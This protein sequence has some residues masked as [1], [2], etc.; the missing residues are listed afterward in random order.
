MN[1]L[2]DSN[3]VEWF[4]KEL[5]KMS[6]NN[7][8]AQ[9]DQSSTPKNFPSGIDSWGGLQT[10]REGDSFGTE[11]LRPND[12]KDTGVNATDNRAVY[13]NE[14]AMMAPP[15]GLETL[16]LPDQAI[17]HNTTDGSILESVRQE[18]KR[19]DHEM[20]QVNAKLMTVE[21][22]IKN[23]A[24][25]IETHKAITMPL[26]HSTLISWPNEGPTGGIHMAA[27]DAMKR[28]QE[29]RDG[30]LR[31]I[32]EK[33]GAIEDYVTQATQWMKKLHETISRWADS[34]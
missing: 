12:W 16:P 3:D 21:E 22:Y 4:L 14:T 26:D 31:E 13:L 19:R 6:D 20:Q 25:W 23:T 33:I 29:E 17:T 10:E 28:K 8:Q 11:C 18:L 5:S 7:G 24:R 2:K 9:P 34:P 32:K 27:L 30:E 1:Q 15:L